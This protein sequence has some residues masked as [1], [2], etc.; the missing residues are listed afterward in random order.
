[1]W[2]PQFLVHLLYHYVRPQAQGNDPAQNLPWGLPFG[3]AGIAAISGVS[4][5]AAKWGSHPQDLGTSGFQL[6]GGVHSPPPPPPNGVGGFG[7][8]GSIERTII[9]LL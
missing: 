4:V 2:F 5:T 7:E 8:K 9:Q 6:E 1:M 3:L